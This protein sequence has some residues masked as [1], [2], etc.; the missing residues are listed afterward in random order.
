[1]SANE[2]SETPAGGL[3]FINLFFRCLLEVGQAMYKLMSQMASTVHKVYAEAYSAQELPVE[4]E[5]AHVIEA[6][7]KQIKRRRHMLAFFAWATVAGIFV[8][9]LMESYMTIVAV[10][11]MFGFLVTAMAN[12]G[13][14][15]G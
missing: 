11:L 10:L 12:A 2:K 1:M 3:V 8:G 6:Q 4:G 14:N 5:G 15:D 13:N 7:N 9:L